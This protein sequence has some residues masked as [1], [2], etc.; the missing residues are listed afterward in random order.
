MNLKILSAA[1]L[2][3]VSATPLVAQPIPPN[4]PVPQTCSNT[5][6]TYCGDA[7]AVYNAIIANPPVP[8]TTALAGNV[9]SLQSFLDNS[10]ASGTP[11]YQAQQLFEAG[12]A[13]ASQNSQHSQQCQNAFN[14]KNDLRVVIEIIVAKMS[15]PSKGTMNNLVVTRGNMNQLNSYSSQFY[16]LFYAINQLDIAISAFPSTAGPS[17]INKSSPA[18]PTKGDAPTRK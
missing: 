5:A 12:G 10:Y 18:S 17:K 15:F 9:A 14:A 1:F 6:D 13:C 4:P 7:T 16:T 8:A 2:I 3:G 11:L